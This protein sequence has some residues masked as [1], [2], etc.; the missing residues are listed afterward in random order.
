MKKLSVVGSSVIRK[1]ALDKVCGKTRFSA[2]IKIPG[3]LHVKVLRSK[4]AHGYLK[5]ID[6][7]EATAL[8]GVCTV[9]TANDV[10]GSN[11][12]GIIV[13]DKPVLVNNK[14]RK[15]GDPIAIVAATTEKIALQV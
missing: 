15:I 7:S 12:H 8:P 13:K 6:I 9:L 10:P 2:D 3:M 4:V 5:S 1:D 11:S 14:I